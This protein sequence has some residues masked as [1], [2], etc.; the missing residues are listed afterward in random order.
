MRYILSTLSV[1]TLHIC[2]I[3][4]SCNKKNL[5]FEHENGSIQFLMYQ[6][7]ECESGSILLHDNYLDN[8][9]YK[10]DTLT[11]TFKFAN[12]GL[13]AYQADVQIDR[14]RIHIML[15]DTS[16]THIRTRT[17]HE[18]TF[19]FLVENFSAVDLRLEIQFFLSTEYVIVFE[20][21][22]LLLTNQ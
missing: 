7:K 16:S 10:N 9:N 18:D 11:V 6:D 21:R 13:S 22:L 17:I 15:N 1:I 4:T 12:S 3:T 14:D 8:W 20:D 19:W 2:L 5:I